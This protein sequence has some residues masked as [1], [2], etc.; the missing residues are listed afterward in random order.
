MTLDKKETIEGGTVTVN[1]SVPEERAP[2]HFTIEKHDL[3]T[4]GFRQKRE[5]TSQKQNFVTLEFTVEEQDRLLS[6]HCQASIVSGNRVETSES[7][8]S[9]LVTVT[10]Q[11][12][13][14]LFVI[15]S[16]L[17]V[18]YGA[19]DHRVGGAGDFWWGCC[20]QDCS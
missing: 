20:S 16:G 10:G 9:E 5:K 14:L 15:L 8:R 11:R 7:S 3:D 6:F 12:P 1:C 18:W 13:A 2:I 17:L 19:K 4:K